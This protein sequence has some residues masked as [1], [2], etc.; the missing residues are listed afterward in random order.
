M[1]QDGPQPAET[2]D[3]RSV[4]QS[5]GAAGVLG[6]SAGG[7]VAAQQSVVPTDQDAI[8]PPS[9]R[10]SVEQAIVTGATPEATLTLY[11]ADAASVAQGQADARGSYVFERVEPAEG[12]RVTQTVEGEQSERS[13]AV[14]VLSSYSERIP[15]FP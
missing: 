15:P 6:L 12:Y 14:R 2:L 3:R 1:S 10:G 8:Q 9:I 7:A 11:D 4:L 13:T 5:M